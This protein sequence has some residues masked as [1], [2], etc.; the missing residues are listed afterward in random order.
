MRGRSRTPRRAGGKRP[1]RPDARC[2]LRPVARSPPT[3]P[4]P[5]GSCVH[6][7][8]FSWGPSWDPLPGL[9]GRKKG[10]LPH[11]GRRVTQSCM[12]SCRRPATAA[13]DDP[14]AAQCAHVIESA[15][16][17]TDRQPRHVRPHGR[18]Q[19]RLRVA[20]AQGTPTGTRHRD[21]TTSATSAPPVSRKTRPENCPV[22]GG[23]MGHSRG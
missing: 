11:K 2:A 15:A 1:E 16:P 17:F 12:A 5:A 21:R 20:I 4:R 19:D 22:R 10:Q 7:P 14:A 18:H 9:E 8:D 3:R 23:Y 13:G 6:G